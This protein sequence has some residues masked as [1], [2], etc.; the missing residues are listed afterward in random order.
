MTRAAPAL[1]F[2]ICA[3]F[4]GENARGQT[5]E[6][7][8]IKPSDPDARGSTIK[9]PNGT[10]T[11]TNAPARN[12]ITL[13]YDV[14]PFQI[15]GGPNWIADQRFDVLAKMADGV[16]KGQHDPDR[17]PLMRAALQALLADRFQLTIH[18]E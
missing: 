9:F 11:A 16:V 18:R 13:A 17:L 3:I 14:Q 1:L 4:L 6:V 10:F 2:S 7:A 5:F 8:S 15:E 12:L